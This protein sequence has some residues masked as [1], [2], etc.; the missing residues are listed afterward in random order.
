MLEFKFGLKMSP[1]TSPV[2]SPC[3]SCCAPEGTLRRHPIP[4]ALYIIALAAIATVMATDWL[5]INEKLIFGCSVVGAHVVVAIPYFC[6]RSLQNR[7]VDH[8]FMSEADV[9]IH[10]DGTSMRQLLLWIQG[11]VLTSKKGISLSKVDHSASILKQSNYDTQQ[12]S[13][14]IQC[15]D[16]G[17]CLIKVKNKLTGKMHFVE[18][19]VLDDISYTCRIVGNVTQELPEISSPDAFMRALFEDRHDNY[20]LH[21]SNPM[22]ALINELTKGCVRELTF[23]K[24]QNPQELN[25]DQVADILLWQGHYFIKVNETS[26]N[27]RSFCCLQNFREGLRWSIWKQT[28]QG[29]QPQIN[30]NSGLRIVHDFTFEERHNAASYKKLQ[31]LFA[32]QDVSMG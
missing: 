25:A 30:P 21:F 12:I 19:G 23:G 7:A 4:I 28:A 24:I 5:G 8:S 22:E 3:F 26:T 6:L 32:G 17:C 27:T 20:C 29:Y 2:C 9:S 15:T 13:T 31:A 14:L 18:L 11:F 10:D 1:P 16:E